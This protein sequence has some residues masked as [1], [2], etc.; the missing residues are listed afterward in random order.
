MSLP[1]KKYPTLEVQGAFYKRLLENIRALPGVESTAIASGLPLGNNGWQMGFS[2]EGQPPPPLDQR[3]L[4]GVL[5]GN[6]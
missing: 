5:F 6:A 4:M 2:I 1:E 3:P